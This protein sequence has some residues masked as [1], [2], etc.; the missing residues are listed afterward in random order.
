M[1]L[2]TAQ[3]WLHKGDARNA[4]LEL[5][6]LIKAHPSDARLRVFLFQLLAV[7]GQWDRALNQLNVCAELDAAHLLMAQTYGPVVQCERLRQEVLAGRQ[8]PLILGDP[9]PWVAW[10]LEALRLDHSGELGEADALRMQALD[11]AP[12]IPGNLDGNPF[13][14]L[15]DA[16]TRFGPIVE[17][18]ING[19][20]YWVPM[21][22]IRSMQ[23]S[24]PED[25]RDL[26]WLPAEF[27][28]TNEGDAFGFI[29]VRYPGSESGDA[30]QQL[31][32]RTDW[33]EVNGGAAKGL[34]QRMLATDSRDYP[35]LDCRSIQ[36][37]ITA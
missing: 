32:R 27:V 30:L 28:W 29:P 23:L 11:Q 31:A 1:S 36:F 3:T 5:Q 26:V 20:Y 22:R 4:L 19:R 37:D 12:A 21:S 17:A 25:L 8:S 10:M 7:L 2:D 18:M 15:A 35:L 33:V 9:E 13:T 24:A 34:G 6:Q 16:D 14:W